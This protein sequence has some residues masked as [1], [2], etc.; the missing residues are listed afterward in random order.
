MHGKDVKGVILKDA[1]PQDFINLKVVYVLVGKYNGF[2][3]LS[4]KKLPLMEVL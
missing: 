2:L 4:E 1:T 3:I